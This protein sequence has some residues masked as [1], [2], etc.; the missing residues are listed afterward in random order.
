MNNQSLSYESYTGSIKVSIEDN[1]LHGKILFID[2]IIT[3][4]GDTVDE[5][6]ISFEEAVK[7]YISYC[8]ET[9]KSANKPYSG[10]FNVRVGQEFHRKAAKKAYQE[11]IS[12]NDF[13]TQCLRKE[14][15]DEGVTV[16]HM[17]HH[18]HEVAYI[19]DV[20]E[21]VDPAV[22][23]GKIWMTAVENDN[24]PDLFQRSQFVSPAPSNP[25]ALQA[26]TS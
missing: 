15:Q 21:I 7:H 2:D 24:N 17:H 14:L 4:E 16:K 26:S 8:E 18:T 3:Y 22:N 11:G 25:Y 6:R 12:L 10:T 9:G 19:S 13:V 1:C 20:E 23:E 5:L